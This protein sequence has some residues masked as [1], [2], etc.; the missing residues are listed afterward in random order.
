MP[1]SILVITD[2]HETDHCSLKKAH[3]I[4]APLGAEIDVVRFIKTNGIDSPDSVGVEQQSEAL[5]ASLENIFAD[6]EQKR[7]ITSQVIVTDDIVTWV[8]NY[9][10]D[11]SFD[12][13]IKAGHRSET[14]FHTPCDWELIRNLRVPVLIASQQCWKHKPAVLAAVDPEAK[15]DIHHEL[16]HAILEWAG[17]WA[18]TFDCTIH[19]VYS[20]P[21]S[22]I[23]KELDII[24]LEE[25]AREHRAEGEDKLAT[26]LNGHNLKN[27][28]FHVTAGAPERT[29]P[30]CA[31]ELKAELVIM[32]SMGR[33]GIQ[34][35]LIGNVA[36]KV[37]HHLRTDSLII[38]RQK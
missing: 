15:D 5:T 33:S 10:H 7:T 24:D 13:V 26:L 9:C 35:M 23:M 20:L 6:S 25:Y 18:R 32:G 19:L 28:N 31:N 2:V 11:K 36:E 34:G 29:I 38:E 22:N 30:H 37:M 16:N 21:V 27:V 3:Q 4:A 17:K 14:L 12:L 8:V 1:K